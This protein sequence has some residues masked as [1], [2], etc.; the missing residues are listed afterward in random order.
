MK[1]ILSLILASILL[2]LNLSSCSQEEDAGYFVR[3]QRNEMGRLSV[4]LARDTKDGEKLTEAELNSIYEEACATFEKA[5]S[6]LSDG[7]GNPLSTLNSPVNAVFDINKDLLKEITGAIK[8]SDLTDGRYEPCAG[9][10]TSLLK[11]DSAPTDEMLTDAL[12]H[13]GKDKFE[14][15]GTEAKKLDAKASIDFGAYRDGYALQSVCEFLGESACAY[16]TVTFNGIAGVFGEKPD[17]ELFKIEIGDG[18]DGT[19]NISDGYVALV[20]KNFGTSYDYSDGVLTPALEK[21]A[22][23]AA[24]AKVCAVI[25]SVGY[26]HGADV[27][28]DLYEKEDLSFEAVLTERDGKEIF[29][30]NADGTNLYTPIT[31]A[32]S[33]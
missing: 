23:Y 29:T 6:F 25:A 9:S 31:T 5:Y 20:S 22:V 30:K 7:E 32:Q 13:I 3:T 11:A 8:L 12:S 16:G 19:F 1:K 15:S 4:S 33:E 26:V 28:L 21:A 2:I 17:G 18:A 27:L 24:D 14:F 10:L